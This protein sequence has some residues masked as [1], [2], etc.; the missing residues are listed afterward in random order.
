MTATVLPPSVRPRP[1]WWFPPVPRRRLLVLRRLAYAFVFLDVLVTT[2]WVADVADPSLYEPLLIGR[3][4][5]FPTPT[6]AV[7][8]GVRVALLAS[9]GLSVW[10]RWPRITGAACAVL[11]LQWMLVAFSFGKVDHDR[12]AFLV[13][14]AVAAT[15]GPAGADDDRPD[16]AAG[17]ALRCVQVAVTATYVLAG[18][19]KLRF[20]GAEWV[21]G[22]TMMRAL[23][24]RGTGLGER[25]LDHPELLEVAQWATMA[26]ELGAVALLV[27]GPLRRLWLAQAVG[28][29]VAVYLTLTITFLPHVF[30]LLAFAPLER[31]GLPGRR[32]GPR[33]Q[34]RPAW[35]TSTRVDSTRPDRW[36]RHTSGSASKAVH[37]N[38]VRPSSPPSMQA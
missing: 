22:A 27:G 30:C 6:P 1:S 33:S 26:F 7:V 5:P 28:F 13:L 38:S 36:R 8:D 23:V 19:A 16:P 34:G 11:Y 35:G 31:V 3:L 37:T 12:L 10:S 32:A 17:W 29:H 20:G 24:R 21:Q 4:L 2:P 15:V 25:L 9:A 14:L 18:V